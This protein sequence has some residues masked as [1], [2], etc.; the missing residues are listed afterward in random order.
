MRRLHLT[1]I[2][3]GLLLAGCNTVGVFPSQT[4]RPWKDADATGVSL[5]KGAAECKYQAKL[6]AAGATGVSQQAEVAGDLYEQCMTRRG[7]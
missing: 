4:G 2:T 3:A 6:S 5:G 7:Y 1:A